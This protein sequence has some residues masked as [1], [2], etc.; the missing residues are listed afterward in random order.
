MQEPSRGD[1][2]FTNPVIIERSH[3]IMAYI[4]KITNDINNKIYIGKTN[5]SIQKRWKEHCSD[6]LKEKE[7]N[8]PL[9]RAMNKY[10]IEYFHIEQV[11]ECPNT[12]VDEREKYWIE[13]YGSFKY[14]YNATKG[15]DGKAYCDYDLVFALWNKGLTIKEISEKLHYDS[16][17]CSDILSTFGI[18]KEIRKKR[19]VSTHF[20]PVIQIDKNTN[21]ILCV[22]PSIKAAENAT[23]NGGHIASVCTGKRKTAAGYKWEWVK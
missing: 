10:G 5:F 19:A 8:R 3:L 4:Y 13:Y 18:D 22:Y 7:Q 15:G 9:Y 12:I 2:V 20:K 1:D 17:H 11:E 21:E 6:F 14:G 23:G 16:S